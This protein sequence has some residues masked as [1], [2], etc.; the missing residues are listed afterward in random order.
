MS[1]SNSSA[2]PLDDALLL[3]DQGFWISPGLGLLLIAGLGLAVILFARLFASI[4]PMPIARRVEGG[5]SLL[6]YPAA[7]LLCVFSVVNPTA[8]LVHKIVAGLVLA[9]LGYWTVKAIRERSWPP[10]PRS[11]A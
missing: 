4:M 11:E 7:I 5:A 10:G 6:F 1:A 8:G 9:N 3:A 2:V